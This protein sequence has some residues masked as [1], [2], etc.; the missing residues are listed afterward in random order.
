M[1]NRAEVDELFFLITS[2]ADCIMGSE[3]FAV[4]KY[5]KEVISAI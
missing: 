2:G 4:G 1:P 3:E 5:P